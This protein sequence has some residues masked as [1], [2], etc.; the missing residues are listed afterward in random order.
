M[1]AAVAAEYHKLDH[2]YDRFISRFENVNRNG[3][4]EKFIIQ[5]LQYV[6]TVVSLKSD[7]EKLLSYYSRMTEFYK[8]N[9]PE[10]GFLQDYQQ[11][12]ASLSQR[13]Q[14]MR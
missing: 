12:H 2:N 7:A 10:T 11:L 3:C 9:F 1:N 14:M 6:N 5:Y 8:N 13:I 4:N